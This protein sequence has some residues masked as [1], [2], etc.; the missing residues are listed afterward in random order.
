MSGYRSGGSKS[1]LSP[2]CPE[3]LLGLKPK[4][5][6]KLALPI[7]RRC[8]EGFN[9]LDEKYEFIA[10]IEREDIIEQID[11]V[12]G[13]AGLKGYGDWADRWRDW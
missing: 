6:K 2:F 10:T 12:L 9:L 13:V 5:T 4:P 7:V 3:A 11:E 1:T 8:I